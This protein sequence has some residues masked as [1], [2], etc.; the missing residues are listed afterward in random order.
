MEKS[1]LIL[2]NKIAR[3]LQRLQ[4][5]MLGHITNSRLEIEINITHARISCDLYDVHVTY[6]PIDS[7]DLSY[8]TYINNPGIVDDFITRVKLYMKTLE[9]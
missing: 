9:C 2:L 8:R 5:S 1:E 7:I 3:R 6:D 4:L